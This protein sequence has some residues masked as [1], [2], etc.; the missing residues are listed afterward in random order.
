MFELPAGHELLSYMLQV[1]LSVAWPPGPLRAQGLGAR[2]CPHPR[3]PG[4][5]SPGW[6]PHN[7]LPEKRGRAA[8]WCQ[9]ELATAVHGITYEA[10][11]QLTAL[12]ALL[13]DVR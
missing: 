1:D 7:K 11:M 4:M 5:I 13:Y 8:G 9:I 3:G 2:V 12:S 10:P 6:Y